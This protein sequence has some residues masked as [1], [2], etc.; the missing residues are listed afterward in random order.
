M[1]NQL[2]IAVS[3]TVVLARLGI[4]A[5]SV[6]DVILKITLM[7]VKERISM[8]TNQIVITRQTHRRK[9]RLTELRFL[10]QHGSE[11]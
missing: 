3:V 4:I 5:T 1:V 7:T 9:I 2:N 10:L 6:N 11:L 8:K